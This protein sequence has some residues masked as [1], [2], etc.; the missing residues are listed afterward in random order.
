[1]A[2][3]R[4]AKIITT[5]ESHVVTGRYRASINFNSNDW[6]DRTTVKESKGWDWLH[7][8]DDEKTLSIGSNVE[9]ALDLEKRYWIFGRALDQ[10]KWQMISLF[11]KWFKRKIKWLQ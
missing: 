9:Y 11:S 4:Q 5:E 1:M 6:I 2:F 7:E 8:F 10:S 3:E